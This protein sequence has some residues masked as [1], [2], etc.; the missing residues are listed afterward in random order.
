MSA[1]RFE[2]LVELSGL[3]S[4]SEPADAGLAETKLLEHAFD[5][6]GVFVRDPQKNVNILGKSSR[7]AK[8]QGIPTHRK[9]LH[10]VREQQ[11]DKLADILLQF[12]QD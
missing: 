5:P 10:F 11:F 1:G 8:R 12:L 4:L 6:L 2:I 9:E 3:S 7:P